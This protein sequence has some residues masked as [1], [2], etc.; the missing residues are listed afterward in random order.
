MLNGQA[1]MALYGQRW[2]NA[3]F[4]VENDT[5][6]TLEDNLT[7]AVGPRW[8]VHVGPVWIHPGIAYWR[9]LDKPLAASTPNYNTL[10]LDVPFVF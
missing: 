7:V 3:P 5:T 8:H 1:A 2:L 4:A 9:G 6:G 10:Q